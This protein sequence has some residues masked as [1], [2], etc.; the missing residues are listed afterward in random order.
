MFNA[1]L[2]YAPEAA[3]IFGNMQSLFQNET[4]RVGMHIEMK[5]IHIEKNY[6]VHSFFTK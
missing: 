4:L 2:N 6:R 3:E 5:L 1:W